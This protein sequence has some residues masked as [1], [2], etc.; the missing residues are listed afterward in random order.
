VSGIEGSEGITAMAVSPSLKFMAIC[1][2]AE[3]AICSIYDLSNLNRKKKTL[4]SYDYQ[5]KKFVSVAFSPHN[6]KS[7]LLT[8]TADPRPHVILWMWDKQRCLSM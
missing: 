8:L 4:C 5:S 2:Q 7:H 1:E 3:R 6:E